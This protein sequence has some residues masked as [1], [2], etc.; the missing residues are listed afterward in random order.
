MVCAQGLLMF[1]FGIV[2]VIEPAPDPGR[3]SATLPH[4]HSLQDIC[5]KGESIF[6]NRALK[7]K[8]AE[9]SLVIR[10]VDMKAQPD[11]RQRNGVQTLNN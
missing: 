4:R 7:A 5:L 9:D 6:T 8:V 1:M 10:A 3:N 2:Q 11:S